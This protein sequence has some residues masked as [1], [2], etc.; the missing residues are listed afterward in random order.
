MVL[1]DSVT[2]W[3][4][5]LY[6]PNLRIR[7][8]LFWPVSETSPSNLQFSTLHAPFRPALLPVHNQVSIG[9]PATCLSQ[10]PTGCAGR[11]SPP[12]YQHDIIAW[13]EGWG[14]QAMP[15]QSHHTIWIGN[16]C[17]FKNLLT[18]GSSRSLTNPVH[19]TNNQKNMTQ[20][21]QVL[22]LGLNLSR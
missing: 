20:V 21:S 10:A 18:E 7:A 14:L 6:I 3:Q 17:W 15:P 4:G 8:S 12:H 13:A 16:F 1:L 9:H 11:L 2:W 5:N 19:E 22:F